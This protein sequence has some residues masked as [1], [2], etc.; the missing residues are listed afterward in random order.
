M[1]A[2]PA[3]QALLTI[4]ALHE[5]VDAIFRKAG[6]NGI[7]SGA[8]ARVIVAGERDACKAHG[9]YRIEGILRTI[10]AGK[11]KPD[12]VPE[13]PPHHGPAI[14]KVDAKGGFANPA[15]ELGIPVLAERARSVGIAALAINEA[16]H[17]SALWAEVEALTQEGLAGLAICPSYATVAPTGG[18]SALLGTNPLAFGWPR[19]GQLPYVFDFATSVAARGE[20]EIHRRDGTPLPQGWAIDVDGRPTTN[21]KR[22]WPVPCFPSAATRD[23]PS[24]R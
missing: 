12:T 19:D 18:N 11:V 21:P 1:D 3:S 7:Q 24:G 8:V 17:F 5:R 22:R 6:L 14:V 4:D 2:V 23:R 16:A 20:I 9:V 10:K 15:I 13:L